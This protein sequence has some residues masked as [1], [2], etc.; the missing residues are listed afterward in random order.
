MGSVDQI[1]RNMFE[2]D[3]HQA[4]LELESNGYSKHN[5]EIRFFKTITEGC[6]PWNILNY[7]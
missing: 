6:V 5:N 3:T 2:K 1:T 4:I 7:H